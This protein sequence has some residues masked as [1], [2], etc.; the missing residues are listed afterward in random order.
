MYEGVI[1]LFVARDLVTKSSVTTVTPGC[2]IGLTRDVGLKYSSTS[3]MFTCTSTTKLLSHLLHWAREAFVYSFVQLLIHSLVKMN[4]CLTEQMNREIG[5]DCL[6]E[7]HLS[8]S[9]ADIASIMTT[10]C[11]PR[12]YSML[13]V[14]YL[15]CYTV[16]RVASPCVFMRPV[17][18]KNRYLDDDDYYCYKIQLNG[19]ADFGHNDHRWWSH[20]SLIH[21]FLSIHLSP[22]QWKALSSHLVLGYI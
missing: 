12:R 4:Q 22:L 17:W 19:S 14:N 1:C 5:S 16:L 6:W 9:A 18:A 13:I 11:P 21:L 20:T 15:P 8:Q 2:T 3:N 7:R 10:T